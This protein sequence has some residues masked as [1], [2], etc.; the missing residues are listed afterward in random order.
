MELTLTTS[1]GRAFRLAALLPYERKDGTASAVSVWC[2]TCA[3]CGADFE[4]V[5]G[6][7]LKCITTTHVFARAHCDAHRK[8]RKP[9]ASP[10]QSEGLAD[11]P[12]PML[13][14]TG[15]KRQRGI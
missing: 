2:G 8:P 4:V 10:Q 7:G 6:A 9:N 11:S 3:V 12:S 14:D 5:T 13:E 15:I 1:K